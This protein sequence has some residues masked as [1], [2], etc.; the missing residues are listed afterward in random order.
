MPNENEPDPSAQ[1]STEEQTPDPETP[2][3]G[4]ED[5][6]TPDP[7]TPSGDEPE[8]PKLSHDDA[9]AALARARQ[10]AANYR[11]KL[12]EAE[13]KLADAKT[14]EEFEAARNE[15]I[16]SNRTLERELL[17][18]RAANK[19]GLP[20]ELRELLKGDTADELDAHAKSLAKYVVSSGE[21]DTLSGGLTPGSVGDGLPD[22]PRELARQAGA[23]KR[24]R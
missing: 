15:L 18:E 8:A 3:A 19:H 11:V 21:P 7:E 9:L 16:E 1:V 23:V 5:E 13:Q 20:S 10:E 22:D 17:V 24:R 12:R 6:Q 4:T 2:P 14:P